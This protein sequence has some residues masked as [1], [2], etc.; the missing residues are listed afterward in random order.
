MISFNRDAKERFNR[1]WLE[2][3]Q[4]PKVSGR[5]TNINTTGADPGIFDRASGGGG[6]V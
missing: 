3:P 1:E 4:M 5:I 6:V 2:S